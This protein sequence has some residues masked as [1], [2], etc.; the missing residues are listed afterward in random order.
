[1]SY[2]ITSHAQKGNLLGALLTSQYI[3]EPILVPRR[4]HLEMA[5][6]GFMQWFCLR[7]RSRRPARVAPQNP[8]GQ[9]VGTRRKRM[10]CDAGIETSSLSKA[11]HPQKPNGTFCGVGSLWDLTVKSQ[12]RG[13]FLDV[14]PSGRKDSSQEGGGFRRAKRHRTG[15]G[16]LSMSFYSL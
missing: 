3:A 7:S 2:I 12:C 8:Q 9:G 14:E 16:R 1:M 6:T 5:G 10:Q 11:R 13:P 4:G 15:E